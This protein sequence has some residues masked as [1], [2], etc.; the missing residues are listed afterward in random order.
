MARSSL[1][2]TR[3]INRRRNTQT[4]ASGGGTAPPIHEHIADDASR[5]SMIIMPRAS[6]ATNIDLL[7]C[8]ADAARHNLF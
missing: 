5:A 4:S 2:G 7:A 1:L 6:G 3:G 8:L